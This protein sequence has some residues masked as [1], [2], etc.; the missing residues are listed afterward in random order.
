MIDLIVQL[1]LVL[2]IIVMSVLEMFK[3][4]LSSDLDLMILSLDVLDLI[5]ILV[6]ETS[7]IVL[8]VTVNLTVIFVI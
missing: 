3:T 2:E 4:A 8:L 5:V 7:Q 1:L 6:L